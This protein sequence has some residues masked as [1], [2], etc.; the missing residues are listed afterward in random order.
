LCTFVQIWL[1]IVYILPWQE[2]VGVF[3]A[4]SCFT[5]VTIVNTELMLIKVADYKRWCEELP[6]TVDAGVV[7]MKVVQ[8]QIILLL[9]RYDFINPAFNQEQVFLCDD[10][11][12]NLYIS[13]NTIHEF[14]TFDFTIRTFYATI[15]SFNACKLKKTEL[16]ATEFQ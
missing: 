6:G 9:T 13:N 11:Q 1:F 4:F 10:K 3:I 16:W 14:F 2:V 8:T 12:S 15:Y 7:I 5:S